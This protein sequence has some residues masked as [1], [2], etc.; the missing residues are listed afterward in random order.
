MRSLHRLAGRAA[1]PAFALLTLPALLP[2]LM[3]A[4]QPAAAQPASP[5]PASSEGGAPARAYAAT[6]PRLEAEIRVDGV[7]DEAVW[8]EAAVLDG[9]TQYL[10]ADGRPAEQ[11]TEIRV[12]YAPTA[13]YF[14]IR[15][16]APPGSVRATLADRDKISADDYVLLL[17]DTFDDRQ[18]AFVIGVNPLG[19]QF[20]GVLRDAAQQAGMMGTGGGRAYTIDASPDYVFQSKGRVTPTGFEVEVAVPFKSLR[21]QAAPTQRWGFNALRRVQATGFEDTWAP[22]AQRQASFLAQSGTLAG[23]SDLRRGLVLDLN[24]ELTASA[25]RAETGPFE[26]T[27]PRLGGNVRWGITNNL[28]LTATA[29]PD[30]SQIEADVVQIE[31]D[32]RQTLFFPEKRPFFLEGIELFQSPNQLVYTRRIVDPGF[33]AKL[34]GKAGGTDLAVLSALDDADASLTGDERRLFNVLRL[35]RDLG[36]QSSLGVVYTDFVEGARSNR[37]G[38]L[39][40]RLL[41]GKVYTLTFQGA[42][43]VTDEGAGRFAAPLW[44]VRLNRSGRT[45]GFNAS[46]RGIHG[47]FRAG[48]GFLNRVDVVRANFTPRYTRYGAEGARLERWTGSLTFDGTWDYARFTAGT[49]PNDAKL[50]LNSAWGLRG[51]WQLST[52]L[53][54]ESFKYPPGLY[55]NY[56][57]ERRRSGAVVDTV[58]YTGTDRLFNLDVVGVVATP[59]FKAFSG[60]LFVIYGQ[61]E[62]FYEWSSAYIFFVELDAE[63]R[64][65]EQLR[66]NLLYNHQQYNRKTDGSLVGRRR[67][68]RL[69]AEYQ[70]T[71]A[72]FVRLVGQYDAFERDALR[73]DS[74]TGDPILIANPATGSLSRTAPVQRN[75]F[76][77]DALVSYRPVPGTVVFV[78]Y[79]SQLSDRAAFR[80][81]ALERRRDGFFVKLSYLYRL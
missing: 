66:V 45:A 62:N 67:V 70:L 19:V 58:A 41:L 10:P 37:V 65:T 35:R 2:V 1:L 56:F 33:A 75:S 32:P 16:T 39:D 6:P 34:T 71:R 77:V 52:S 25:A 29:N 36:G 74:R 4:A 47:D 9:F 18:Q 44:D 40:G 15:A 11:P 72:L 23:L 43:S 78:G 28:A 63:W 20:D 68:P 57:V 27:N 48:A 3:A 54:I 81:G 26:T 22:V 51:G 14:G 79:G 53:L 59:R 76:S 17:L 60:N 49:E 38:A 8:Q 80:F 5:Q 24:P 7:L 12:W 31:Y 21:Y 46:L 50:H 30:F 42:G 61:D 13:I 64:P 69:K 73:D 55:E